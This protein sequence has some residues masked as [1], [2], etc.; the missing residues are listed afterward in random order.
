M[1]WQPPIVSETW[2]AIDLYLSLAYG[3]EPPLAVRARLDAMRASSEDEFYR[4]A[5]FERMPAEHP[6]KYSLRLGNRYYPHMKLVIE[7]A[8]DGTHVLFRADTHDRH[9]QPKPNS[10][11]AAAFSELSRNNQE[12][13]QQIESAWDEQGLPTFKRYLRDDLA[14]RKAAISLEKAD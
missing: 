5:A 10:P 3:G 13:A 11:E 14:R 1:N 8:P 4:I 7:C 2:K 9:V 12:L 6:A